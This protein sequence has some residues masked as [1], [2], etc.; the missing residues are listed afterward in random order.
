VET[1]IYLHLT[2]MTKI[3]FSLDCKDL[4]DLAAAI[5]KD[6]RYNDFKASNA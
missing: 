4:K 1:Q 3:G 5:A 2:H 6:L